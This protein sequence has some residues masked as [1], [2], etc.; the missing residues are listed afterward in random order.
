MDESVTNVI[1]IAIIWFHQ[2]FK[3]EVFLV[4]HAHPLLLHLKK[5]I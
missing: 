1:I 5:L 3:I 2:L 4:R